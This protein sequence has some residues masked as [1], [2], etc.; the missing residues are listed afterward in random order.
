MKIAFVDFWPSPKPF[1]A[2]NNFFVH[3]LRACVDGVKVVDPEACDVLFYGPFGQVH[4]RYRDCLKIFYT[5]ENLLPNFNQCHAALTFSHDSCEGRNLRL[6]LWHLYIDWFGVGTYGAPEWLV[7][8]RW[9]VDGC[10]L[11][12]SA[13][14]RHQFCSIVYG[15]RVQSRLQ[16]IQHVSAY[17][18][19]DVFGKANPQN[20]IEDGE[21]AK[22]RVLS[23]YRFSLCY[24]NSIAHGYHTEKLLHGKIAG[25][26]PIYYGHDSVA[27]DFNPACCIQASALSPS[28]LVDRIR[29]IDQ[30]D[31]LYRRIV[32]QPLFHTMPDIG[33]LCESLFRFIQSQ[34]NIQ[35]PSD[36]SVPYHLHHAGQR[37][38]SRLT[39][40]KLFLKRQ[41]SRFG[42]WGD[43]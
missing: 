24:E 35:L 17:K 6:P 14:P 4:R 20:P 40:S 3:A 25:G 26:I 28:E 16:A 33:R 18:P 42:V 27:L 37:A 30:N 19:V 9:L 41:L 32:D 43:D 22:V 36:R 34:A 12:S 7:P 11:R 13:D 15:K 1:D 2:S 29:E 39:Q 5:G 21:L 8:V 31:N 23:G 38:S 10:S